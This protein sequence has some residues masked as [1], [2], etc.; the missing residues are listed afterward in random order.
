MN[1]KGN[2][3][4]DTWVPNAAVNRN[5]NPSDTDEIVG[6]YARASAPQAHDAIAAARDAF[7]V[8]SATGLEQ[9]QAIPARI[10]DEFIA[11]KDELGRLLSRVAGKP[12]AEEAGE[13][14]CAGQFFQYFVHE[15]LWQMGYVALAPDFGDGSADKPTWPAQ[16]QW[17]VTPEHLPNI[18]QGLIDHG[19][20]PQEVGKIMGETGCASS[21]TGSRRAD[22]AE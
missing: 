13:V 4:A 12:L 2:Y 1:T 3:I 8:W 16:P 10:G 6:E 11:R 7:P 19:F 18:T 17:F 20:N 9:R 21:V 22:R 14:A 15:T 5:I